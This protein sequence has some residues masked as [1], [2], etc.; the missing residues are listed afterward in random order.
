MAAPSDNS[1][2]EH[3]LGGLPLVRDQGLNT[4][5]AVNF[6][7]WTVTTGG[8]ASGSATGPTGSFAN[9]NIQTAAA[10]T[11]GTGATATLA[12]AGS[13]A[14]GPLAVGLQTGWLKIYVAGSPV[15]IPTF[16]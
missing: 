10:S 1:T 7:G 9:L 15:F 12:A 14:G 11:G 6:S 5:N 3:A 4:N 16:T 13:L 8:Q 2:L